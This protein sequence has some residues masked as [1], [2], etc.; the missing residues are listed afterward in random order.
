MNDPGLPG[1]LQYAPMYKRAR[2]TQTMMTHPCSPTFTM[3]K[4]RGGIRLTWEQACRALCAISA[5][6]P[7]ML[8]QYLL[9]GN[10]RKERCKWHLRSM[11][12]AVAG[13]DGGGGGTG[14]SSRYYEPF[15]PSASCAKN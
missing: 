12:A 8:L 2:T 11:A 15:Y 7:L 5:D 9:G 3:A 1:A 10:Q 14:A 6:E 13:G 4:I